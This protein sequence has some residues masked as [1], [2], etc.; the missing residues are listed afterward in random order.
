MARR[1]TLDRPRDIE[2]TQ[3]L[4]GSAPD[5][6]GADTSP[7]DV[8]PFNETV[9][10]GPEPAV[11]TW[12]VLGLIVSVVGLCATLTGLLAPEGAAIGLFGL[13]ISVGGIVASGR[14]GVNGRGMAVL[15]ALIALAAVALAVL[16][17][18]GR[19]S[20][21]SSGTNEVTRWHAW[22]AGHWARLGHR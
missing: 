4:I 13:L 8:V 19:L 22:L 7:H 3:V 18:T 14:P 11:S 15:A 21:L 6:Y 2:D 5:R 12:A 20:W 17:M 1:N 10:W 9:V 16:A